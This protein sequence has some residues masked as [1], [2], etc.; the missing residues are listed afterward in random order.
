MKTILREWDW[1]N[2][3]GV[4]NPDTWKIWEWV[5]RKWTGQV[6]WA[7]V[8]NITRQTFVLVEQ[9]RPLMNAQVIECVAWLVDEGYSP[10]D[11]I[12]KEILEETWYTTRQIEYLFQWPK[13]AGITTEQTLDYY[14]QV[15][16]NPWE[17][18]LEESEV[19]L[20][21]HETQNTLFELKAFLEQQ[22]QLWK[23]ISPGIWAVIWK[24]ITDGKISLN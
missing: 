4:T 20:I 13:S 11:A 10:E 24:A 23:L 6:V 3:I 8:E 17:Q 21:V 1:I 16:W 19:W 22:E 2:T 12:A 9:F 14:A 5:E 15:T 18:E 7:L